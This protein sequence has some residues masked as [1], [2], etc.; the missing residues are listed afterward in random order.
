[1][2]FKLLYI[3]AFLALFLEP[4]ASFMRVRPGL[5]EEAINQALHNRFP[6]ALS[7]QPEAAVKE[8][9]MLEKMALKMKCLID[10]KKKMNSSSLCQKKGVNLILPT[11]VD[12]YSTFFG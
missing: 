6:K 3:L 11:E 2:Q 7:K 1:M 5:I 8:I 10:L 4:S 9:R 12:K